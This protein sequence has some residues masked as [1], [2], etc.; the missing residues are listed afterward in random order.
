MSNAIPDTASAQ[1]RVRRSQ[2]MRESSVSPLVKEVEMVEAAGVEPSRRDS[3]NRL[4]AHDFHASCPYS[5]SP[6][7]HSE[8]TPVNSCLL[9]S[10][11]VRE[12]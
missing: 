2:A 9:V 3:V 5:L 11:P 1:I 4:M 8:S 10:T 12:R 6:S 7:T